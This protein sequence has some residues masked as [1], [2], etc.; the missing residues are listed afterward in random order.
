[1][2]EQAQTSGYF[3]G[4]Y[5]GLLTVLWAALLQGIP[6]WGRRWQLQRPPLTGEVTGSDLMVSICIP[7]RDE[8][9]NIAGCIQAALASDWPQLEVVV[10][11]DRSSD[12]TAQIA[13]D[14]AP[15]DPRL[16]VVEG[17]EPPKGWAGKPWAA[18]RAAGEARGQVLAFVDAD[19]RLAPEAL[20]AL[21][22]KM[23]DRN[24]RLISAYGT[25]SLVGF[26]ERA[27]IP[28][29]GWLI[30]GS[31][32][33]DA[34]ND[35]GD[36]VAFANGQLIVVERP[37]Y[38][39]MKGHAVVKGE[40]LED[41]RLAEQFKR[42]GHGVAMVVAPWAFSVRLYSSL[43]QILGGYSKNMYEGMGRRPSLALGAVLFIFIGTLLPWL[44]LAGG[45][46]VQLGLGWA[47]PGAFWLAWAALVCGLQLAFRYRL[48]TRDG[49]SGAICW[50]H[51]VANVMLIWIL[52]R[53]MFGVEAEWKGRLFVDG[54]SAR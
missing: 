27:L 24:V 47:I 17:K 49:R 12:N 43:S 33:L 9:E 13:R 11:D 6:G 53:S 23:I 45:V 3:L 22:P 1:M 39:S 37:T 18:A 46:V 48:E 32:D 41:V 8:A 7:A 4:G 14:A 30:R 38:D 54:R 10:V 5:L 36:P 29:V 44:F 25:W 31:V 16:H 42:R 51:P 50:V 52:L 20:R 34:V 21:I 2:W 35:P 19:V 15:D 40:I 26:W 28:T